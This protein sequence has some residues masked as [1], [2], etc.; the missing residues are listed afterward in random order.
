[1][2][3]G[4]VSPQQ[5]EIPANQSVSLTLVNAG[6]TPA[7]F[8]SKR[9]KIEQ[10]VAPGTSVEIAL[11]PLPPGTYPFVEEFHE[12]LDTGRGTIVVK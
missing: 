5:V 10:I 6:N 2:T 9:L 8:E 4:V 1:M 11:Q 3:D 12:A 7:E